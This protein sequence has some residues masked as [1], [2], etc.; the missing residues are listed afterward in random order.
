MPNELMHLAQL[1]CWSGNWPLAPR[2]AEESFE[3]AEQVGQ[4][5]GGP[6]AMRAL[7]DAHVGNVERARAT[8]ASRLE[9]VEERR[10]P[11]RSIS[12]C[13]GSSSSRSAIPRPPSGTSRARRDRGELRD[14]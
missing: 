12:A 2:Y 7:I 9:G 1:E 6:P 5:F 11:F 8:V 3:L 13:S 14:P 10:W 4:S